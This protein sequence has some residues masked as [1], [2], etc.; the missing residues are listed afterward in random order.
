MLSIIFKGVFGG[1]APPPPPPSAPPTPAAASGPEPT[2][3]DAPATVRDFAVGSGGG[4]P[5]P[6]AYGPPPA[7]AAPAAGVGTPAADRGAK[8]A[9][10][11]VLIEAAAGMSEDEVRAYALATQPELLLASLVDTIAAA[12]RAEA[13]A[14]VAAPEEA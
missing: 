7:Q 9:E 3:L 6:A 14:E 13:E 11:S 2:P 5:V 8:P 1:N 4:A 10:F 12:V